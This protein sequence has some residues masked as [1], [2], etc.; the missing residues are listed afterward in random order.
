MA[1]GLNVFFSGRPAIL[2]DH[3]SA[4]AHHDAID[5]ETGDALF[6]RWQE[7]G[8]LKAR[9]ELV[10]STVRLMLVVAGHF[11]SDAVHA[12]DLLNE[13]IVVILSKGHKYN[14]DAGQGKFGSYVVLHALAAIRQ[15]ARANTDAVVR[16]KEFV[17]DGEGKRIY[18]RTAV[19][20]DAPLSSDGDMTLLDTLVDEARGV[21]EALDDD[22]ARRL[23]AECMAELTD[24]E[25]TVSGVLLKGRPCTD[26]AKILGISRE[27]ARQMKVAAHRK[28]RQALEARGVTAENIGDLFAA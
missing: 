1:G 20:L 25:R 12:E 6:R 17:V 19:S 9:D 15:Y 13:A 28:I 26:A 2:P 23:V 18:H 27:R 22:S 14:P 10:A 5:K 3:M 4:L 11:V 21:D 8:D 16:P 7:E 24:R